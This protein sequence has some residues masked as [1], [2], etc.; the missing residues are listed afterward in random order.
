[1]LYCNLSCCNA[2]KSD[3]ISSYPLR[4]KNQRMRNLSRIIV[5]YFASVSM[6]VDASPND[7]M[8]TK[9]DEWS[10]ISQK[11]EQQRLKNFVF[12]LRESPGQIAVIAAYGGE[13]TCPGE[14]EL[15][16][17]RVRQFL[18]RKGIAA[19]RIRVVDAG[20]QR[21]WTIS[22]FIGVPDFPPITSETLNRYGGYLDSRQVKILSSCKGL[23]R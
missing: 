9:F 2:I 13:K 7:V 10:E 20:Y 21:Q 8:W 18:L 5:I 16:A 19:Q 14:A 17:A 22:L 1:V 6:N 15:R 3:L 11:A 12:Q 4:V 23:K